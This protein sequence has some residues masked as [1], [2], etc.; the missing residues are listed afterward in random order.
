MLNEAPRSRSMVAAEIDR[1]GETTPRRKLKLS[2]AIRNFL[3]GKGRLAGGRFAGGSN[4][5]RRRT[6]FRE[7]GK[8]F[9]TQDEDE[10]NLFLIPT[11]MINQEIWTLPANWHQ[12][13]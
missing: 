5:N 3:S 7:R 10:N 9:H 13:T 2:A 12:I 11:L 8:Y 4:I 1:D 6:Q